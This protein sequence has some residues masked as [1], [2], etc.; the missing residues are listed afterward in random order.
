VHRGLSG[1]DAVFRC[2][3]LCSPSRLVQL[4]TLETRGQWEAQNLLWKAPLAFEGA[5]QE[6]EDIGLLAGREFEVETDV[7]RY[8]LDARI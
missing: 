1:A 3:G 6:A 5:A 7:R 2:W 8:D 4:L